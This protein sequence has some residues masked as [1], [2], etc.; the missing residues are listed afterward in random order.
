MKQGN[1]LTSF[2]MSILALG[3]A[4]YFGFYIFE[5]F[6]NPFS[7]TRTYQFSISQSVEATGLIVRDE[8]IFP[9]QHGIVQTIPSNG[10]KVG[11][12]Q[13][14]ALVHQDTQAMQQQA[15]LSAYQQEIDVLHYAMQQDG[16]DAVS[17]ARLDEDILGGLVSLRSTAASDNYNNLEQD[18]TQLKSAVLKRAFTYGTDLVP[19]ELTLRLAQLERDQQLLQAVTASTTHSVVTSL[20]GTFSSHVDGYEGVITP[21]SILTMTPSELSELLKH[22]IESSPTSTGKIVQGTHWYMIVNVPTEVATELTVG[23]S[24]SVAFSGTFSELVPMEIEQIGTDEDGQSTLILS[25]RHYLSDTILLR[26]QTV[27]LIHHTDTGLRVPKA[28][29]RMQKFSTTDEETGEVTENEVLGVY[30][31]VA[32]RAEFKP[33]TTISEGSDFYIVQ[34][35]SSG[36]D[37]LKAGHDIIVHATDLYHGKPLQN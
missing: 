16:E 27:E 24:L 28:A 7:S 32:G 10:E 14:V 33:V 29:L 25:S 37:T 20:S 5:S 6:N 4:C 3:L 31:L 9:T 35:T 11:V 34:P 22:P 19:E 1:L 13:T 36:R 2:V 17:S 26:E 12:G 8:S 30:A 21:S 18:I 15:T 23:K